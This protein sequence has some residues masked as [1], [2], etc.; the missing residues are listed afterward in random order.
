M[1]RLYRIEQDGIPRHAAEREGTWRLVDG[2][3]FGAWTEGAEIASEGLRLLAPVSPSK[4]VCV[5]LN[6][7]DHAAEQN[8]ALPLEPLLFMKPSTAVIGPGD[9][10]QVPAWAGRIDHEAELGIVIGKRAH[11]VPLEQT[12]DYVLGLIAVNDVTARE[13]QNTDGQYTRCKGFD[14]F[15]P[16]G[17]CVAMGLD[18]R[19]LSVRAYVNGQ[20]R[21]DSRTRELIF[22]IP[23][24]IA[25]I[26]SVMTLLPGDIISTGTP[27]GVGP[28]SPGDSVTVH[29]EG[30][31]ALTNGVV[32]Q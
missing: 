7:K 17:P 6:Y 27:S 4:I 5:G 18:G 22:T 14:T 30:V 10:I 28:I 29:V 3:I 20:V 21:Q 32:K 8:K 2:D 12:Q 9:D 1:V 25:Y 13:L 23:E 19:D 16:I 15:A 24:L 11:R 26:T 31:G